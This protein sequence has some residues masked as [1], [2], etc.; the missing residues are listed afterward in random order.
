M[1]TNDVLKTL[2]IN[3]VEWDSN[4]DPLYSYL[5]I[6]NIVDYLQHQK[7]KKFSIGD[8]VTYVSDYAPSEHGI[9]KGFSK[10]GIQAYVVYNCN[11]D[12]ENYNN[13]TGQLTYL[14]DLRKEWEII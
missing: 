9:I 10:D 6:V 3:N 4:G 2:K 8:K 11:E 5:Q 7:K 1:N 13:Y 14:D 12:W